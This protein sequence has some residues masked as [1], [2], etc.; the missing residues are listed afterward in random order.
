MLTEVFH[1]CR[2]ERM[3][4]ITD[5][6]RP[7]PAKLDPWPAPWADLTRSG[8]RFCPLHR[9]VLSS[10]RTACTGTHANYRPGVDPTLTVDSKLTAVP[11]KPSNTAERFYEMLR[12]SIC[13]LPPLPAAPGDGLPGRRR[14]V[15]R[16]VSTHVQIGVLES[17][18]GHGSGDVRPDSGQPGV[19]ESQGVRVAPEVGLT[20]GEPQH[21]QV[22]KQIDDVHRPIVTRTGLRAHL[23]AQSRRVTR[24]R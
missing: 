12:T 1:R 23:L 5:G 2:A 21:P 24:A 8:R 9:S 17:E 18:P 22:G 15:P 6:V 13:R 19:D 20:D 4:V 7:I 14:R 3:D 16:R 10:S 11:P